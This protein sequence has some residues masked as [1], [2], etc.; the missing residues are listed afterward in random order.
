MHNQIFDN[1]QLQ[2]LELDAQH[3]MYCEEYVY[4][5]DT[6]D[7]MMNFTEWSRVERVKHSLACNDDDL[8]F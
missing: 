6:V 8:P 1:E 4:K 3:D 5:N 2:Q 7:G